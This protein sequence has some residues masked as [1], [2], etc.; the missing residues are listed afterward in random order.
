MIYAAIADWA[1]DSEYPVSFMCAHL[2]ISRSG[3]YRWRTTGGQC[4]RDRTD[5]ALTTLI[6]QIHASLRGDPGVRRVWAE[7]AARA[8]AVAH[9]RVWRLMKAAGLQGRHPQAW[10]RTTVADARPVDAP[11]LIGQDFTAE[12]PDTRWCAD[13]A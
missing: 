10:R 2:G 1:T 5:A 8:P 6:R 12:Q 4:D 11:D 3:Y 13:I 9:K 7:L